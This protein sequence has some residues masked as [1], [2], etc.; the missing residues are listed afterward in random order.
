MVPV[1]DGK[2]VM[3]W[4]FLMR[5]PCLLCSRVA[6]AVALRSTQFNVGFLIAKVELRIVAVAYDHS[7]FSCHDGL[8]STAKYIAVDAAVLDVYVGVATH[9]SLIASAEDVFVDD[10]SLSVDEYRG[11]SVN[12]F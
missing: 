8:V 3:S 12:D 7:G 5:L 9:L 6:V 2:Q 11:L 10:D 4:L 1:N